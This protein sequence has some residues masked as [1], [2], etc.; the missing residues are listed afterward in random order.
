MAASG[1]LSLWAAEEDFLMLMVVNQ[2]RV[3]RHIALGGVTLDFLRTE[4]GLTG[5][6]EGCREGDCGACT[7][8]LGEFTDGRLVYKSVV[9]CLLPLGDCAGKHLVTIEGLNGPGLNPLQQAFV[10]QGAIQCGFCTPGL[11]VALT[12]WLLTAEAWDLEEAVLAIAGNICRCTGY[13]AIRR[14][15]RQVLEPL[16]AAD[17]APRLELLVKAGILPDYFTVIPQLLAA[18]PPAIPEPTASTAPPLRVAGGTDLYVQKMHQLESAPVELLSGLPRLAGIHVGTESCR[19][20]GGVT[21]EQMRRSPEL[22]G[23]LPRLPEFLK[24]VS[25]TQIR[26]RAT[27]AGNLVNASP[28]GDLTIMLLALDAGV[29][30]AGDAAEREVPLRSFYRGYKQMDLLETELVIAIHFP[31]PRPG[32][33]FNF[34]KTSRRE[35][36]D[37]ASVN[38]ACLLRLDGDRIDTVHLAAGGVA[39]VPLYLEGCAAFLRGR[40][41]EHGVLAEALRVAD[42][43]IAPI[44]DVRGTA[45]YKRLLLRQ[46]LT[47]HFVTLLPERFAKGLV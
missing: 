38:S 44:D 10:D 9:S 39:P 32:D 31:A 42:G 23:L 28:I 13:A 36:L 27:I 29:E 40:T 25:S 7:V 2:N 20:G 11:V 3:E 21:V 47:A 5:V 1:C 34:E 17:S 8:L 41:L 24:L 33:R 18:L 15:V 6:K 26:N 30:L 37:I 12:G 46:L 45:D 22:A 14:A 16:P 35:H 4:L 19:L 43:E